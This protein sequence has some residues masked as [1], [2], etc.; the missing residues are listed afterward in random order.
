LR[1]FTIVSSWNFELGRNLEQG[2]LV[3]PSVQP[4]S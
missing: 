4:N 2:L 3:A 1:E